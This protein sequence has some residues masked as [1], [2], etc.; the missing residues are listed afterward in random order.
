MTTNRKDVSFRLASMLCA[1][2]CA[3]L[4][5]AGAGCSNSNPL[6][7]QSISGH[8]TCDGAPLK[9][10]SIQF[11]P[12]DGAKVG[13][14]AVI[15][16]GKYQIAAVKGLPRGKYRVEIH[17]SKPPAGSPP[18]APTDGLSPPPVGGYRLNVETI[19][20]QFNVNSKLQVEVV[21]GSNVFDFD[22][23]SK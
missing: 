21:Q 20:S 16:D 10:G 8:V 15:I 11:M 3:L 13:G 1:V 5:I 18:P 14:G 2:V 4:L 17:S 6:E 12:I 7:R 19:A 23:T 22:T 9:I